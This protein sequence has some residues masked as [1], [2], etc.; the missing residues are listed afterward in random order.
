MCGLGRQVQAGR[1]LEE[2]KDPATLRF[3]GR[4]ARSP[5]PASSARHSEGALTGVLCSKP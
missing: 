2:H 4:Q 5:D 1:A 3:G